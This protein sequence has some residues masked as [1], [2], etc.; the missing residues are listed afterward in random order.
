MDVKPCIP[1]HLTTKQRILFLHR[2]G[3]PALK[4]MKQI[5]IEIIH[6][7]PNRCLHCS[8]K[9]KN[10]LKITFNSRNCKSGVCFHDI[11]TKEQF[12]NQ[13]GKLYDFKMLYYPTL[14]EWNGVTSIQANVQDIC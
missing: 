6:K 7:C 13:N 3:Y 8:S 11:E 9:N 1:P 12:L 14:N 4:K 10:V 5:S 2:M